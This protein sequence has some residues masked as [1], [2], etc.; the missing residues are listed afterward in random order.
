M[1]DLRDELFQKIEHKKITACLYTDMD[2]VVSG[3]SSAL[4]EAERIGLIVD[5]SVSEGTDVLAGDLLMQIS[6]TPKQIAVAEDMII[7]HISKFSGVATA[8]K[9]FV[10]K[11]GHHM[12]IVCGSWK[13]MSS[14]IKNE[15]RTAIETGGAHVRISDDP[16]VY[17]DKNYVAMFGGIQASL[18]AAAQFNDRKKCIQVRGRFENGDIV[19][20]AW[21]AITA[22]ADIVYVD[23]GRIDDLRRI[24]QSLKPVLQEMEATADY[25]K[26]EF[27]FGGGVR[28]GDLDALKEAGADIVGVGR[29][30]VDA[31]LMDLRLEVTKA[32]DPLYAHGDYDLLDKSELKIEGIFL[33][34]TNL[35]ELAVVVAEEIGINAEDV[36]VI[37]VRDGTVAL[38]ILQKRLDPSKFIAKEERIL[39]R[40]RDLMGITLSEEAHISSNGMLGWIVGNDADIEEGLQA[41]EMSQSLVTQIK[42][43]I[44]NRVIVFPTGTEVERGEIED[45]NTP[46]I[47]GKFAA[48]GFSVDKGEILKD[49]V[50][51]FSRKLW[52]AAEKGYSVS[53]TTGGVGAENKDH[54]VEAVLRLDP[55]ACTPYIAK[56]QVG[57]GRHSK[58]GIRIAVGQLG[59][60]TFIALPGPNDEVSVCIDTV[61]RGISE[62]WSKEILAGE[63]ARILRTRLKEKIGVMM[64]YHHN[65]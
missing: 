18:T 20:E 23:T 50:E 5:F 61:V 7:G 48:A 6:G 12:R 54:S 46:L 31:P 19:R 49:D 24:T 17:L 4:N 35:T 41:M 25:R 3:I 51:L 55:Q 57:H 60:T 14:N 30:I 8:A 26:V 32:E 13:K 63:L 16:M 58:D 36:L 39:R 11:A 42:E 22:G 43:S 29:S 65:A 59:L 33:N 62:G 45:T 27:A 38:D 64:H 1:K 52:R 47:M 9:A 40:L 21:T 37:D 28:Y 53:I 10:Q 34:Q 2:G 15:L 56:F 44:S